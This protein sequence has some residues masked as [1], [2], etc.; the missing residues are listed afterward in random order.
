MTHL[1]GRA[2][3]G[4]HLPL[5]PG[6][7][8]DGRE[9]AR[10][11]PTPGS[12]HR[13]S[14]AGAGAASSGPWG[15]PPCPEPGKARCRDIGG[16]H[17]HHPSQPQTTHSDQVLLRLDWGQGQGSGFRGKAAID[18]WGG[19][20]GTLWGLDGRRTRGHYEGTVCSV[21]SIH[22][23]E[24]PF[25]RPCPVSM[26]QT[27]ISPVLPFSMG[28]TP[29]SPA[30]PFSMGQTPLS[31]GPAPSPWARPPFPS[32]LPCLHGLDSPFSQPYPVARCP[33]FWALWVLRTASKVWELH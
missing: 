20:R 3:C 22:G 17:R 5:T 18:T 16:T 26:G 19:P 32:A 28:Q 11:G 6:Q 9:K 21:E 1:A 7:A 2:A 10:V 4:H 30:L 25:P 24:S 8:A 33:L 14:G 15:W 23:P 31:P 27:P 29:I 12:A 13:A